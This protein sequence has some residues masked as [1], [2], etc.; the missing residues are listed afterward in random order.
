MRF[1]A[2]ETAENLLSTPMFERVVPLA[3]RFDVMWSGADETAVAQ[4]ISLIA[5][6]IRIVSALVLPVPAPASIRT[7]P[8][9]A[10]TASRCAGFSPSR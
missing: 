3:R 8:S 7:G 1:S 4:R 5:F 10:S 2:V 9:S 6:A